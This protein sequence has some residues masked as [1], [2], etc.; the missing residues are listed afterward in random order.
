[1]LYDGVMRDKTTHNTKPFSLRLSVEERERLEQLAGVMPLG[2]Y[3][4]SRLLD[5][6]R[7]RKY[8][9]RMS[10]EHK[11]IVQILAQLSATRIPQNINQIAKAVNSGVLVVSPETKE[12]ILAAQ[13]A[14]TSMRK[15][16]LKALGQTL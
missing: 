11:L 4:R 8:K 13:E 2:E 16:L 3:I 12:N 7:P 5:N 15:M 6:P 9:K 1:M 14:V 10:E